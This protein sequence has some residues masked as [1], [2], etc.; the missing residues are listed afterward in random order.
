MNIEKKQTLKRKLTV[1]VKNDPEKENVKVGWE[2][3]TGGVEAVADMTGD[4]GTSTGLAALC[5]LTDRPGIVAAI[6]FGVCLVAAGGAYLLY[7]MRR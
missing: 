4:K 3:P 2:K 5:E 1:T 7:K 6:G